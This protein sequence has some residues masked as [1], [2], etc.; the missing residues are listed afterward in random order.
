LQPHSFSGQAYTQTPAAAP[1]WARGLV[2]LCPGAANTC[3]LLLLLLLLLWHGVLDL[4][5]ADD[6][7]KLGPDEVFVATDG[8]ELNLVYVA[9][10]RAM[11]GLVCNRNVAQLLTQKSRKRLRAE[12][13]DRVLPLHAA[14]G[15]GLAWDHPHQLMMSCA[16]A[17]TRVP[18]HIVQSLAAL[19]L[20]L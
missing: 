20:M 7:A 11:L 12:V 4:Q 3:K 1:W 5:L 2:Q 18:G 16:L 10:T 17:F 9:I 13:G 14:S 6:F 19:A 8:D 15:P